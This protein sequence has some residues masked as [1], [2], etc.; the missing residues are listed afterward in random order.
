MAGGHRRRKEPDNF[1]GHR[2][3]LG[4]WREKVGG[5]WSGCWEVGMGTPD[6]I[7]REQ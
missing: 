1:R 3:D 7:R 5:R 4:R 6:A 2:A